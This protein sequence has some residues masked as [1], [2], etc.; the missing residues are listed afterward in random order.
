MRSMYISIG[1]H[2]NC[3]YAHTMCSGRYSASDFTT[4]GNQDFF[5][6]DGYLLA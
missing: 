1:I 6:H 2:S 3:A 4:I 5:K